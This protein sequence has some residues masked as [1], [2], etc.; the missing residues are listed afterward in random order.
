MKVAVAILCIGAVTFLVRVLIGLMKEAKAGPY[1]HTIHFAKFK[2]ARKRGELIEM[3]SVAQTRD[4]PG[5]G[6]ERIAL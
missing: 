3:K 1:Q 6:R 2:P 5:R 4:V